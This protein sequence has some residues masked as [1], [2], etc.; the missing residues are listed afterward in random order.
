MKKLIKPIKPV[1]L[2]AG[3]SV[4][5]LMAFQFSSPKPANYEP[6]FMSRLDMEASVKLGDAREIESPGKIWV[7]NNFI[8]LIEQYKGIHIIDNSDPANSK[9]IAFIQ[10]DGCTNMAMKDNILYANNAVDM[11]GIKPNQDFSD[12]TVVARNRNMLPIVASPEPWDDWYF[13][14]KLPANTV[15][16]RWELYQN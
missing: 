4:F 16:V 8:L 9:T 12:F 6:I 11:I 5:M 13:Y 1:L 2:L 14:T 7:Y 10:I 3:I 15:I